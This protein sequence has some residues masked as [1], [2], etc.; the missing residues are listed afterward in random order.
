VLV[1]THKMDIE[2][3]IGLTLIS[4]TVRLEYVSEVYDNPIL[5]NQVSLVKD[6]IK[7]CPDETC[8]LRA[9]NKNIGR[10]ETLGG[11]K[12]TSSLCVLLI[13][14]KGYCINSYNMK[15]VPD[16]FIERCWACIQQISF[17]VSD[18]LKS[19]IQGAMEQRDPSTYSLLFCPKRQLPLS[20]E[21]T[22]DIISNG[23]YE[24]LDNFKDMVPANIW[25][26]D[27]VITRTVL[28]HLQK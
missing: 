1:H 10:S 6:R 16:I 8:L 13:L 23:R 24:I 27:D 18:P 25:H 17:T 28:M 22:G 15:D 2:S 11:R 19:W 26:R 7:T 12:Y 9:I 5:F 14:S 21:L 20:T 3:D 4:D